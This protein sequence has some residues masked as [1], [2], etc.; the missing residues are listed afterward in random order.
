MPVRKIPKNY[1]S[2]TGFFPS[3]KNGRSMAFESRL[4][5]DFFLLLEF[6]PDVLEYEEQ[7]LV[8]E[9]KLAGNKLK[10]TPDCLITYRGHHPHQ[11]I[12]E[13]KYRKDLE[14]NK[15]E[16]LPRFDLA[17]SYAEENGLAFKVMT[18]E[19]IRGSFLDNCRFIYG[20][21][22]QPSDFGL[23]ADKVLQAA[24]GADGISLVDLLQ[25]CAKDKAA[26]PVLMPVIWHLCFKGRL[27]L[28]DVERPIDNST[29][30]KVV[31]GHP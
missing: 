13:V 25:Q 14:E 4:E 27:A 30:L 16:L 7:P 2:V 21:N 11:T 8:L 26:Q 12:V 3:V 19:D 29:I 24:R 23:H 20:F 28:S 31:D 22:R 15:D 10:Y 5:R 1:R 9:E 17:K 6:D 18:D